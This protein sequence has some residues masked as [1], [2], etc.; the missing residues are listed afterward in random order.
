MQQSEKSKLCPSCDGYVSLQ[1]NI[2]PYCGNTLIAAK[3]E[4]SPADSRDNIKSLSYEE[5]LTALYPPPYKPKAIDPQI[6]KLTDEEDDNEEEEEKKDEI[7]EKKSTLLPTS[8]LILGVNLLL[9]SII[10]FVF[11]DDGFLFLKWK[12]KYWFLY[13]LFAIPFLYF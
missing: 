10:L 2:C 4:D 9:F 6:K 1:V 3:E 11:S 7:S 5:T 13:S 8:L 12:S